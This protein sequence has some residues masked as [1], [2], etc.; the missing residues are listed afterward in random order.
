M[1]KIFFKK[2]L[3]EVREITLM[4]DH[5]VE[6][7]RKLHSGIRVRG[8][9]CP[10][11]IL[12]FYQCGLPNGILKIIEKKE[13]ETP[14]PIQMQAI[15]ALMAGINSFNTDCFHNVLVKFI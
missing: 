2:Y 12:N 13:F 4:K 10:R 5:E 9:H 8:K 7:L 6:A 11:P 15:P 1:K 14:F 3:Y